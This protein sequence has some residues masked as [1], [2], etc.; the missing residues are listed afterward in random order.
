MSITSLSSQY[1]SASFNSLVQYSSSGNMYDGTG[2]QINNISVPNSLNIG[3]GNSSISSPSLT[4]GGSNS[5]VSGVGGYALGK[6]LVVSGSQQ[7]V[8]GAYNKQNDSTSPFIVGL[9]TGPAAVDRADVFKITNSGSIVLPTNIQASG[10]PGWNGTPGEV[11]FNDDG[12]Y[13]WKV[14]AVSWTLIS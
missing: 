5:I 10:Q 6:Y 13:L 11:V 1:I 2:T 8:V 9:G 14:G 3:S 7:T 12:I 4:V